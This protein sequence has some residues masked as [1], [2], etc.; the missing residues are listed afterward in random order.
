MEFSRDQV[1]PK[2][3]SV[4]WEKGETTLQDLEKATGV[5]RSGLYS[6]FKKQRE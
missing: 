1:L 2:A 4:F 5:D 3:L 6:E